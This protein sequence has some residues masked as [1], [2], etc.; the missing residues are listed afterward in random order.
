MIRWLFHLDPI[1]KCNPRLHFVVKNAMLWTLLALV[2]IVKCIGAEDCP[3]GYTRNTGTIPEGHC[4]HWIP[5]PIKIQQALECAEFYV[6]L[7]YTDQSAGN[8]TLRLFF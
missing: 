4:I 1:L 5:C 7:D 6:P 2:L 8:L 3:S